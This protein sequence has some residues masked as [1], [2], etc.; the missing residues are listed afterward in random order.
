MT[1]QQ[2]IALMHP[3]LLACET[4]HPRFVRRKPFGTIVITVNSGYE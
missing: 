4:T 2:I 1:E 3:C